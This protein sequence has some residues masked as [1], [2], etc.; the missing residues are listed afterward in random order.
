MSA[1]VPILLSGPVRKGTTH[2]GYTF[3]AAAVPTLLLALAC[4][5]KGVCLPM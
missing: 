3:G 1:N 2:Q 5:G 4:T